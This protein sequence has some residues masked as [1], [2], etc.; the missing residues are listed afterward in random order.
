MTRATPL[1]LLVLLQRAIP[2]ASLVV[3][4]VAGRMLAPHLGMSLYTCTA[5]IA[6]VEVWTEQA[7]PRPGQ[8]MVFVV[9]AGEVPTP[10]D[11][12]TVPA[13]G[14]TRFGALTD[15]MVSALAAER[16]MVLT[17]DYAPID[18]LMVRQD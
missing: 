13:P 5:V 7:R 6:V 16:G 4:I 9:V 12:V 3:E 17:D 1:W 10:V 18:R 2:A 15:G 8:R 14:P 11:G